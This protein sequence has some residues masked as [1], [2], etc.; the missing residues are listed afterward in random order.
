LS[1]KRVRGREFKVILK[2]GYPIGAL[3]D[4]V[5]SVI[6]TACPEIFKKEDPYPTVRMVKFKEGEIIYEI[7]QGKSRAKTGAV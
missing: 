4:D 2:K 1:N 6:K 5:A 7:A 3:I